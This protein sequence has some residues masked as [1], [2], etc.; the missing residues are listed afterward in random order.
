MHWFSPNS[1]LICLSPRVIFD[2]CARAAEIWSG[3]YDLVNTPKTPYRKT[4]EVWRGVEP[5]MLS[6]LRLVHPIVIE[7]VRFF[8]CHAL[9]GVFNPPPLTVCGLSARGR[10]HFL[11]WLSLRPGWPHVAPHGSRQTSCHFLSWL[12][13]RPGWP[14]SGPMGPHMA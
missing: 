10:C 4:S 2:D 7:P 9:N 8:P 13:S 1:P 14:K 5:L 6:R 11:S 3:T 12:S